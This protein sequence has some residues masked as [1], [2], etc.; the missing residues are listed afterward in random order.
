MARG[1]LFTAGLLVLIVVLGLVHEASSA[2]DSH[3]HYCPPSSCGNI[4]NISYPFRLKGDPPICGDQR[5][6]LSCENNQTVLYLYAGKYYV[7]EINY[8]LYTIRVVDPGIQKDN[9]SS[10]PR[11]FLNDFNFSSGDPFTLSYPDKINV[12]CNSSD[13][14]QPI[15]H[16]LNNARMPETG[17]VWV[18]CEKP[19]IYYS[20]FDMSTCFSNGME[21]SNSSLFHSKSYRYVHVLYSGSLQNLGD[22]CQI[23]QMFPT[24]WPVAPV[25][26]PNTCTDFYDQV[27][28][29]F[30]L[31]WIQVFCDHFTGDD[32]C[33]LNN[34][35]LAVRCDYQ[36][37]GP[38]ILG[39]V[40]AA[41][42]N[43]LVPR[44]IKKL[45]FQ[46]SREDREDEAYNPSL[47]LLIIMII[48]GG[49]Y[50]A[51]KVVLWTPCV[52]AFLIYKW[53]R[54]HLS[55]YDVVEEFL[56]SHNNLMP[57]RY[58]YS[59]I[60]KMTKNFKDKLGEGGY[61]TVFKGTLRS[62][63]LVAIK[64]LGKSK[65]NGQE[66]TNEVATIGRIHHVNVVQ[67]IGFCVEGS[68]RALVYEFMPNG[69][70]NNYIFSPEVS[71][72]LSYDKM[73]DIALGVARG[74]EYLHQG[75]VMQILHFDIKPHNILLDENFAPKVSDFGLAKLYP[76]D[77]SIVSLTAARGTLGYMAPELFY[78]NIGGVS[79][80]A[81][82][83]S[84]GMLLMEMAGRRKNFNAFADHSSQVYFPTWVYDQ[85]HDG[86]DIEMEDVTEEKKKIVK[87]IIMVALWC[88][89]MKP[90]YRPSMNK[91]V[92]MLE[93]KDESLQMPSKPFLSSTDSPVR[94]AGEDS[95][96][97]WSSFQSEESTQSTQL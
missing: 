14:K 35:K 13:Q 88:I 7:Q 92:E 75:C 42:S 33:N 46:I 97:T 94:D 22:S 6:N 5:Y 16:L 67:L 62:G 73:Y 53:C 34:V 43:I 12:F 15:K 8:S 57:I 32:I 26:Y 21:S 18:K 44:F 24:A 11:Y 19:M 30:K 25:G 40:I 74:I 47:M 93:G 41:V 85:L 89:Q 95:N 45:L 37:Y 82:V 83:Y 84:F 60:R 49:L 91:V 68:K 39:K 29:G 4:D 55:M 59:E 77:D 90:N 31:S 48:Y 70:L 66:F 54:R 96:Q 20:Y 71:T 87:K 1:M 81:D 76:V 65:A 3:D 80:K 17:V 36:M 63:R 61:G 9:Y 51:A 56:Q 79:Y 28:Y 86:K 50:L 23:E 58:S 10:I 2:N 27:V 38:S 64:M 52:I 78:K 69:S 72:L